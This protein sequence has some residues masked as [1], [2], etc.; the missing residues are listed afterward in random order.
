MT[1]LN[2]YARP[3]T[4][5]EGNGVLK[6]LRS[7]FHADRDIDVTGAVKVRSC[8]NRRHGSAESCGYIRV[9]RIAKSGAVVTRYAFPKPKEG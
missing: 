2:R 5:S 6:W 3:L 8:C 9:N 4:P 7:R 1:N